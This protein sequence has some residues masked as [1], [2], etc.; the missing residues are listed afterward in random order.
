M[1]SYI[2][3]LAVVQLICMVC[4]LQGCSDSDRGASAE[5]STS[6]TVDRVVMV[7][8]GHKL[9]ASGFAAKVEMMAKF[10]GALN[11]DLTVSK[12]DEL[13]KN[14]KRSYPRVFLLDT[15][16]V[17]YA[18]TNGLVASAA[19]IQKVKRDFLHE[20]DEKKLNA[21]YALFVEKMGDSRKEFEDYLSLTA[22]KE[23]AADFIAAQN[24]TNFPPAEIARECDQ[25]KKYNAMMTATNALIYARAT[26]VWEQLKK[27]ADFEQMVSKYSDLEQEREDK[28]LWDTF[29][30]QQLEP[31]PDVADYAKTLEIG[32]F[33]PPIEGDN[34]LMIMRVDAR[35][36][37]TCTISRIFFQLPMFA[38]EYTEA[39]LL[40]K[41]EAD[42]A[43]EVVQRKVQALLKAARVEYVNAKGKRSLRPDGAKKRDKKKNL[44]A[45]NGKNSTKKNNTKK[46]NKKKGK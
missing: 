14:L 23:D 43:K 5:T 29:D 15:V 4:F 7:V 32:K 9:T 8:D 16:L 17:E 19:A 27:G 11:P 33:S 40:K 24:R 13:K 37:G 21:A 31:D 46:S 18:K 39:E 28:G 30:F 22:L 41:K 2:S 38:K 12:L 36:A 10:K 42:Y 3:R 34:G 20:E 26:N 1:K 44:K 35:D 6:G 45:K 25:A